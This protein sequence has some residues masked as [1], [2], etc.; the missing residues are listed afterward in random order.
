MRNWLRKDFA[1]QVDQINDS[2]K[3]VDSISD[4]EKLVDARSDPKSDPSSNPKVDTHITNR[5]FTQK[6]LISR[7]V[8]NIIPVVIR[9]INPLVTVN[10]VGVQ[11]ILSPRP[12]VLPK[13]SVT[14]ATRS[15]ARI[16][17]TPRKVIHTGRDGSMPWD[18]NSSETNPR[19]NYTSPVSNPNS[20][21]QVL[22]GKQEVFI[23]S[24]SNISKRDR[25]AEPLD[26]P[27]DGYLAVNGHSTSFFRKVIGL[28]IVPREVVNV[29]A[30]E[31]MNLASNSVLGESPKFVG[32]GL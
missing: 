29:N 16:F 21:S 8:P 32:L 2:D 1:E 23:P 6:L 17:C 24:H 30:C 4:S 5:K 10:V 25:N 3:Q 28:E 15:C 19:L 11:D 7:F 31:R 27:I 13:A 20:I 26:A 18:V 22:F 12:I 14:D 9:S